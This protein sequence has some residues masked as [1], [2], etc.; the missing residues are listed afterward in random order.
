MIYS[1]RG[2]RKGEDE[3]REDSV[4]TYEFDTD[5]NLCNASISSADG[6]VETT[7]VVT[8]RQYDVPFRGTGLLVGCMIDHLAT[9]RAVSHAFV[10]PCEWPSL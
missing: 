8:L 5:T 1:A 2:S 7:G 9:S 3:G 10:L 4:R 6:V